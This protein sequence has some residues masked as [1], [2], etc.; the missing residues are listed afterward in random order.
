MKKL[1]L[2][3]A[4]M[5]A[6]L[7]ANAQVYV[8]GSL[9]F[10]SI[11]G[12]KD[13]K[14]STTFSIKPEAGYWLSDNFAVGIQLGYSSTNDTNVE[15]ILK[16][17]EKPNGYKPEKGSGS[18]FTIAPYARYVFAKAGAASFFA[19]GGI[20]FD[21]YGS[22]MKGS[23]FGVGIRPGVSFAVSEKVNVLAKLGYIGYSKDN[24]DLGGGEKIGLNIDNTN[25]ELGVFFNF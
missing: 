10:E 1:F 21:S 8:G 19:D 18:K 20:I 23:T 17:G 24:D 7:A 14:A 15:G 2:M 16:D 5:V 3:A 22:D 4:M 13:A 12:N 9:G 11:K 25:L 6:T